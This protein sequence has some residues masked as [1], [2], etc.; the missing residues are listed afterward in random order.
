MTEALSASQ[1]I[2]DLKNTSEIRRR[3]HGDEI[4]RAG[5]KITVEVPSSTIPGSYR[6]CKFLAFTANEMVL[7]HIDWEETSRRDDA[8]EQF[9][10]LWEDGFRPTLLVPEP[11]QSIIDFER[12]FA[13]YYYTANPDGLDYEALSQPEG[14]VRDEMK[15]ERD[16]ARWEARQERLTEEG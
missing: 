14:E 6:A 3:E 8:F 4:F 16:Q 5:T 13:K 12:A 9:F 1:L 15:E 2:F 11:A 7:G 10:D